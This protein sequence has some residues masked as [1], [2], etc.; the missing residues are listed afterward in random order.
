MTTA[1]TTEREGPTDEALLKA[2]REARFEGGDFKTWYETVILARN[3]VELLHQA[4]GCDEWEPPKDL[5]W[6]IVI[7]QVRRV[8]PA[9]AE[10]HGAVSVLADVEREQAVANG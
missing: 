8:R 9:L 1:S 7:D 5:D 6:V 4:T 10:L 2:A 3:L